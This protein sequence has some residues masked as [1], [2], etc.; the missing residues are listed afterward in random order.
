[1]SITEI[2]Q[3]F[4]DSA[5]NRKAKIPP[6]RGSLFQEINEDFQWSKWLDNPN[7]LDIEFAKKKFDGKKAV[8]ELISHIKN[9]CNCEYTPDKEKT[10]FSDKFKKEILK[11]LSSTSAI[12]KDLET[13]LL[14]ELKVGV[15]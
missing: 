14:Q 12:Y 7:N 13:L 1:M 2:E 5:N 4:V 11:Q 10:D 6:I 9:K 3:W 15:V 8:N